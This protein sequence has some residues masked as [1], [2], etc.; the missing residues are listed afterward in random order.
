M[1]DS[2]HSLIMAGCLWL[3][4]PMTGILAPVGASSF[5]IVSVHWAPL[6]PCIS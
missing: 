3:V 4:S 2:K 5:L 6:I 1:P